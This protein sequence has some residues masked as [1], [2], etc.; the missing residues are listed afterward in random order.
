M[1]EKCIENLEEIKTLVLN[2]PEEHYSQKLAILN[3]S[4]VGQH[5]RHVIEFYQCIIYSS[6]FIIN[7]DQ[8]KR[9][10]TIESCTEYCEKA[11][12]E[13]LLKLKE[14]NTNNQV[15]VFSE[16]GE[17]PSNLFRELLYALEHSTHHEALLKIGLRELG[18]EN[19]VS[20]HF[21]IASSTIKHR[22]LCAR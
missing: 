6:N 17:I 10:N 2:I 15:L 7:Y 3:G 4:T 12:N 11:I 18:L 20:N 21:G 13:L 5:I 16:F 22:E 19:I 8:R 9:D 14:V 1:N